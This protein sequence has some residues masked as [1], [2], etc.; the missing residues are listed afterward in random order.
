MASQL[1]YSGPSLQTLHEEYAKQGRIDENAPV[2][3]SS[4]IYINA[5]VERVWAKL[6]DI[7][8]WP[9]FD[10]AFSK[11]TLESDVTVD[12]RFQFTLK[13]FPIRATFAVVNPGRELTW[14]GLSLWFKAI[15]SHKMEPTSDGGTHY[16]IRE[17]FAGNLAALF[18][19]GEQLGKQHKQWLVAFKKAIE[20]SNSYQLV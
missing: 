20:T 17:S 8:S 19:S 12:A 10:P 3:S 6:V 15:D 16:T 13:G 9:T 7:P 2:Y 4:E 11:V 1:F 18:M 14:T 5:P